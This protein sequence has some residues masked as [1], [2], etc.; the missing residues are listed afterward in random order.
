MSEDSYVREEE[1]VEVTKETVRALVPVAPIDQLMREQQRREAIHRLIDEDRFFGGLPN[2]TS[3]VRAVCTTLPR[4]D[5]SESHLR[6]MPMLHELGFFF[7]CVVSFME[8]Y[9]IPDPSDEMLR[10]LRDAWS[11]TEK[12][13][14]LHARRPVA[15]Q[16]Y[17]KYEGLELDRHLGKQI[18]H[19]PVV[20]VLSRLF[21]FIYMGTVSERHAYIIR[22]RRVTGGQ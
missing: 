22:N 16:E 21:Y 8:Y 13:K 9:G 12:M 4:D 14:E 3:L 1:R 6:K 2:L 7:S 17:F 20:D 10:E 5:S 15:T 19:G 11:S 18:M